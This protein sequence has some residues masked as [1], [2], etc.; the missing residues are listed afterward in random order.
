ME[1]QHHAEADAWRQ[2]SE[3]FAKF[4][5]ETVQRRVAANLEAPELSM[6]ECDVSV[7][8]IDISGY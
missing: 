8:F 6:R 1:R 5:P 2:I 4:V 7:L 3:Y